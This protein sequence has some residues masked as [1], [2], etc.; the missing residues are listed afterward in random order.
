LF[1][2][3]CYKKYSDAPA[4]GSAS[5]LVS[6][7]QFGVHSAITVEPTRTGRCSGRP[8]RRKR[9]RKAA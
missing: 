8:E 7:G 5:R 3:A 1:V 6:F 2:P 9:K 4:L